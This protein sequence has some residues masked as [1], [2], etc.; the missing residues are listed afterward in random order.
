MLTNPSFDGDEPGA[1]PIPPAPVLTVDPGFRSPS[2]WERF[3]SIVDHV[4]FYG[5]LGFGVSVPFLAL[6]IKFLQG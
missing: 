3:S 4:L 6:I 5:I 2:S 1:L